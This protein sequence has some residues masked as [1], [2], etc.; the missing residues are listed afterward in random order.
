M[1]VS[2]QV[3]MSFQNSLLFFDEFTM[4][5]QGFIKLLRSVCTENE[6]SYALDDTSSL[7]LLHSSISFFV[8]HGPQMLIF[9]VLARF[10]SLTIFAIFYSL[11]QP[12]WHILAVLDQ[13]LM[14]DLDYISV[15]ATVVGSEFPKPMA[16]GQDVF[17]A[18]IYCYIKYSS[19][20]AYGVTQ[21][22]GPIF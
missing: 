3:T 4:I 10:Y 6:E 17:Y 13:S 5:L 22:E 12:F 15:T 21:I 1:Q 8:S 7:Q 16:K 20:I 2:V 11:H 14:V 19:M 18:I 9:P